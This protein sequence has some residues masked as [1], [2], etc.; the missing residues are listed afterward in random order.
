MTALLVVAALAFGAVDPHA[1]APR[2]HVDEGARV[3]ALAGGVVGVVA[4]LGWYGLQL[5]NEG[6]PPTIPAVHDSL[7]VVAAF[8]L[9]LVVLGE[10][11]EF[12]TDAAFVGGLVGGGVGAGVGA[13]IDATAA[14]PA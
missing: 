3:G 10:L 13:L 14:P 11:L 9:A 4:L 6:A 2:S 5:A 1:E 12:S 8:A 7:D